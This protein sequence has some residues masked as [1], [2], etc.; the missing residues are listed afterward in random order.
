MEYLDIRTA[1]GKKTGQIKAREKVHE[2][3]DLHGTSHVWI[4]RKDE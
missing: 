2:D 3:G 1:D 4:A